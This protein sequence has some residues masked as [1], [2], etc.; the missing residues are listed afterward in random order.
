M[1]AARSFTAH[2]RR[3]TQAEDDRI[4][5]RTVIYAAGDS[6][7][8]GAL[9]FNTLRMQ[10]LGMGKR[11]AQTLEHGHLALRRSRA[12][13]DS[14][15][16]RRRVRQRADHGETPGDPPKRQDVALVFEQDNRTRGDLPRKLTSLRAGGRR[17][18]TPAAPVGVLE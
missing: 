18:G 11:A 13:P 1:R 2:H 16:F 4:R 17:F 14:A 6:A 9:D 15:H 12:P 7:K 5:N 8:V 10:Y 3:F